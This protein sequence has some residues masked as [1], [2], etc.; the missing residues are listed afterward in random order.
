MT[1]QDLCSM[2]EVARCLGTNGAL[3]AIY[4]SPSPR[5]LCRINDILHRIAPAEYLLPCRRQIVRMVVRRVA[6]HAPHMMR[7]LR[8]LLVSEPYP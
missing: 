1:N 6:E 3:G 4:V 7:P 2:T 5:P 8:H